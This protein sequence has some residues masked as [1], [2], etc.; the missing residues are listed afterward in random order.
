MTHTPAQPFR[1]SVVELAQDKGW[2][3]QALR[4]IPD[5]LL[6]EA[7]RRA[8]QDAC[9]QKKHNNP[10]RLPFSNPWRSLLDLTPD[11]SPLLKKLCLA[12]QS[13]IM[14]FRHISHLA[15]GIATLNTDWQQ[16]AVRA[17]NAGDKRQSDHAAIKV[18]NALSQFNLARTVGKEWSKDDP[19]R[20]EN[21]ESWQKRWRAQLVH[22]GKT[23][24]AEGTK[25]L[26][27]WSAIQRDFPLQ[28]FLVF[29][30]VRVRS[31]GPPGFMFWSKV[32]LAQLA[33]YVQKDV[34]S[35]SDPAFRLAYLQG[36]NLMTDLDARCAYVK[37]LCQRLGL[38]SVND[39]T[40]Y[41]WRL[42]IEPCHDGGFNVIG[43]ER[44]GTEIF[45]NE[46]FRF[47]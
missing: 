38:L 19:A 18:A 28:T 44:N 15:M 34:N 26:P 46:N 36:L 11:A 16:Q 41:V 5:E 30:W 37:K 9:S 31:D 35:M 3:G 43:K 6:R 33:N 23:R 39:A 14:A 24:D 32:A 17:R 47:K 7:D 10:N 21:V 29:R 20:K 40:C 13:Q 22:R 25:P 42:N 12:A 2:I 1:V 27:R 45:R 4:R 8:E